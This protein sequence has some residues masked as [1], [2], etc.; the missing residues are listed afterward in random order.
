MKT[1]WLQSKRGS[2]CWKLGRTWRRGSGIVLPLCMAGMDP[3]VRS[4][5]GVIL[6]SND[7]YKRY[8]WCVCVLLSESAVSGAFG[9]KMSPQSPFIHCEAVKANRQL[10]SS[11]EC[12]TMCLIVAGT[13]IGRRATPCKPLFLTVACL[14]N[15]RW[16]IRNASGKWIRLHC[17]RWAFEQLSITMLRVLS[18]SSASWWTM[19]G[20]LSMTFCCCRHVLPNLGDTVLEPSMK[21]PRNC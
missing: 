19:F 5:E 18:C 17:Q 13:R 21:R 11:S 4:G 6:A 1:D 20:S 8:W 15:T 12:A 2:E 14:L 3:G 7:Y 9:A 16:S 10:F